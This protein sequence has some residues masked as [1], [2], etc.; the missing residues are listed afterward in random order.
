MVSINKKNYILADDIIA[1]CGIFCKGIRNGRELIKKK[2]IDKKYYEYARFTDGIWVINDGKSVKYDKVIIRKIYLDKCDEYV[3]E[4]NGE[5]VK[6]EKGIE[7]APDII[8]LNYDEKFTDNDG[9][10]L[11]IMALQIK[12]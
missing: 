9:N 1:K 10:V 11:E 3:N 8:H 12:K 6:D 5:N 2:V 4:I 7:T